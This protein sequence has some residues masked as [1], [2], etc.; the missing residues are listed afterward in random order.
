MQFQIEKL[1]LW[2]KS[3]NLNY[4]TI[5]FKTNCVNV[6]TG[7]SRT[8][9]SAI[10]PI[11][12]YCLA[13]EK[14]YIPTQTIRNSCS[15]FGIIIKVFNGKILLARREPGLQ[16]T[17]SDMMM[18]QDDEIN[19]PT[20]PEKNT[21]LASVKKFLDEYA[22]LSF[23]NIDDSFIGCRPSFRDLTSFVFQPQNV[24]ANANILFYKTDKTD[25]RNKLISIFPYILG[26][27]TPETLSARQEINDLQKK[28]KKLQYDYEKI[29]ELSISWENEIKGWIS[30]A[31][32]LGLIDAKYKEVGIDAQLQELQNLASIDIQKAEIDCNNIINCSN[33]IVELKEQENSIAVDLSRYQSRYIEMT[34]LMKDI[35]EYHKAL[36][37]QAERL[38]ISKWIYNRA[39]NSHTCPICQQEFQDDS[40]ENIYLKR[41]SEVN[42]KKTQIETIPSSFEREYELTKKQIEKLTNKLNSIQR[43][44]HIENNK[45]NQSTKFFNKFSL[46]GISRFIGKVEYASEMISAIRE[47]GNL[48]LQIEKT[49]NS[50]E[51]LKRIVDEKAIQNK[52]D[53]AIKRISIKQIDLI[54]G[55]DCE[56][57]NDPFELDY[58]NLTVTVSGSDGRKDYLWE[59]G[60][61]SNWLSY[62]IATILGLHMFFSSFNSSVPNFIV[63]D[64]PSQVYFPHNMS[65]EININD[66]DLQAVKDIFSTMSKCI[67]DMDKNMQIIVLEHADTTVYGGNKDINEV[68]RWRNGEKLI[69]QEWLQQETKI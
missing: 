13:S 59:L 67:L 10:I 3:R 42:N 69:P 8:G 16:K 4:K 34:K 11:I 49:K 6:I 64:Q 50:I 48:L 19:I 58:K 56:R 27:I 66:N 52:I 44:I 46:D 51:K 45:S 23:L 18:I 39:K 53:A 17:T 61:G 35:K 40:L 24:I 28:L 12:D 7:D 15:W 43:Q 55:L 54:K 21:N 26:A 36:T 32:E 33:E 14:C 62:H 30:V 57:P 22:S 47:D 20:I 2:P 37:I 31:V 65:N 38:N 5:E 41:L 29:S 60:S 1:I 9:K 68:C 63:F 25:N